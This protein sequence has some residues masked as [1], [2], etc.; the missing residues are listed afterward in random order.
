MVKIRTFSHLYARSQLRKW[1]WPSSSRCVAGHRQGHQEKQSH[2]S[3]ELAQSC[4][5]LENYL[6]PSLGLGTRES[7]FATK[8]FT[9]VLKFL[10][11]WMWVPA[12]YKQ[13]QKSN[14]CDHWHT[15]GS[16]YREVRWNRKV[17][18][19]GQNPTFSHLYARSQLRNWQWPL[20]SRFVAGY[21]QGH[22]EKDPHFSKE[23]AQGCWKLDNYLSPSL[24][25]GT[26][27]SSLC[28]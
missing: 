3:K 28:D 8:Q 4:W 23:L 15:A 19:N 17:S 2:F 1:Q 26:S 6:S 10:G 27:E 14:Q 24:G 13:T 5:K 21:R 12:P 20:S 16:R 9:A 22:P 25:L 18:T 7:H 11:H